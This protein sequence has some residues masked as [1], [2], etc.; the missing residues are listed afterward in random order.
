MFGKKKED[1]KPP[2][3]LEIQAKRVHELAKELREVAES[4]KTEA[5]NDARRTM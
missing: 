2:N 3:P 5:R 1:S 4:L